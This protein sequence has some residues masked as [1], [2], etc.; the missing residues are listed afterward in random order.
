MMKNNFGKWYHK[1]P[2]TP[3]QKFWDGGVGTYDM[4]KSHIA[5]DAWNAALTIAEERLVMYGITE[6]KE[7][8]EVLYVN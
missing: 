6:A 1:K 3:F 5:E 2:I 7:I 8:L 4:P